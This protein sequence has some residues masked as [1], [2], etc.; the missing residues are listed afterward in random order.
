MLS[1]YDIGPSGVIALRDAELGLIARVPTIAGQP[2]SQ[3]GDRGVSSEYR[4][5]FETGVRSATFHTP[6]GSDGIARIAAFRRLEKLPFVVNAGVATQDILAPWWGELYRTVALAVGFLAMSILSGTVVLRLLRD[7]IRRE[8]LLTRSGAWLNHAQQVAR[9]GSF[10]WNAE[11]KELRWSDEHFRL[12]GL[13]PQCEPPSPE[14]LR[15]GVH[16][17]DWPRAQG[18]L[19]VQAPTGGHLECT[20]RTVWPDGSEHHIR[21][22]GEWVPG[23]PGQAGRVIGTAQEITQQVMF[24]AELTR[25]RHHLEAMVHERTTQLEVASAAAEAAS[26]TKSAF[27]ANMSHEI[28][29]PLNAITGLAHMLSQE[30][31][32][33]AQASKVGRIELAGRHLL[34]II[35]AILDLS[36][37]E[38]GKLI[39]SEHD[40]GIGA[41]VANVLSMVSERAQAKGIQ[42]RVECEP[43]PPRLLGDPTLL[44]QALLNYAS[45][46]VKFTTTGTVTLRARIDFQTEADALIRFEVEDTGEG[47]HPEAVP[48][49]FMAFEQADNSVSR[50]HGGTG[51]GLA[52]TRKLAQAMGG[53]TGVATQFG[54]GSTFWFT[55]RLNKAGAAAPAPAAG[56]PLKPAARAL[57]RRFGGRRILLAEDESTNREIAG[58]LLEAVGLVVEFAENGEQAVQLSRECEF[59]LILMDLQMAPMDGLEATRLIRAQGGEGRRIPIIAISANAFAEDRAQCLEA[60]MDDFVSKPIAAELLYSALLRSLDQPTDRAP[61]AN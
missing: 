32:P 57:A 33:S 12:W 22:L 29:T 47:I 3:L 34:E 2:S 6:A 38:A 37:I 48:R 1:H 41:L 27:L 28:R 9:I 21:V 55:A 36:K 19:C 23:E 58:Y 49:L 20:F 60:G 42:L 4:N 24:E 30:G 26:R 54:H 52:I 5:L 61:E 13:P 56:A 11:T 53:D 39:L 44:Q 8:D 15:R 16:P 18:M 35:N 25:H 31:L 10:D 14:L 40:V 7:A 51:L 46:A 50:K 17:Q 59:D 43:M 45:N